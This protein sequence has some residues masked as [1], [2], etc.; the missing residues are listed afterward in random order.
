MR[1]DR[2]REAS[3]DLN[4]LLDEP[5]HRRLG[6]RSANIFLDFSSDAGTSESR[7]Q[8]VTVIAAQTTRFA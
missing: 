2:D 8:E 7:E 6:G 1:S 4:R 3:H 5:G